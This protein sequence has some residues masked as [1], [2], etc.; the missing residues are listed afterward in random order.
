MIKGRRIASGERRTNRNSGPPGVTS[1]HEVGAETEKVKA[2][3]AEVAH[4]KEAYPREEAPRRAKLKV[5]KE[6][7]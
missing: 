1:G 4:Q 3:K 2:R 6:A 5:G 7:L